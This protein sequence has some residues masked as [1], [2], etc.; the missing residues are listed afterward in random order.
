M[1]R[2]VIRSAQLDGEYCGLPRSDRGREA[3]GKVPPAKV[4]VASAAILHHGL[5]DVTMHQW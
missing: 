2:L 3:A 5:I 1:A 4:L